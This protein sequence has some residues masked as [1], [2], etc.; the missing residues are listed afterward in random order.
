[1]KSIVLVRVF[2]T[3]PLTTLPPSNQGFIQ[4]HAGEGASEL[5]DQTAVLSLIGSSGQESR[6]NDRRNSEA[7][8]RTASNE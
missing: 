2:L 1:M 5:E 6:W 4:T 3:V 8:S 7:S